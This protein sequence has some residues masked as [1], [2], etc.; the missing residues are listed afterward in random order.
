[1]LLHILAAWPAPASPQSTAFWPM[2]SNKEET[3]ANPASDPPAMNVS[4]PPDAPP[5]P[6]ETGASTANSPAS[7]A[8]CATARAL[9]TSTVEQSKSVASVF[10]AGITSAATL[11]KMA[12]LGSIVMTTSASVAASTAFDA[13][14]TPKAVVP[15]GSKP[16]TLCPAAAKFAAI[17]APMFPSPIKP[18]FIP[19]P[20]DFTICRFN[21]LRPNGCNILE[22]AAGGTAPS[23]YC[24]FGLR[25]LSMI[26]ARMP[27][28]KSPCSILRAVKRYSRSS[29]LAIVRL[30]P[31]KR[32]SISMVQ[33]IDSG[34]LRRSF[35][36]VCAANSLSSFCKVLRMSDRL[37][38]WKCVLIASIC[39]WIGPISAGVSAIK[40]AGSPDVSSC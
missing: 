34:E 39:D 13:T 11:R 32:C 24:H 15:A 40:Q 28:M 38:P 9:S 26:A 37:T 5:M 10:I 30:G 27:S 12:P 14:A 33:A 17:G 36:S 20:S 16:V 7:P 3:A 25:S 8:S 22:S 19:F 1:M 4:V 29:A 35:F 18:M 2:I 21:A 23:A 31:R 6:P